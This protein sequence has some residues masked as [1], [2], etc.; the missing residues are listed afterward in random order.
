MKNNNWKTN[1]IGKR[2]TVCSVLKC[3]SVWCAC[4]CVYVGFDHVCVLRYIFRPPCWR[5]RR[6]SAASRSLISRRRFW[7]FQ[8]LNRDRDRD[9]CR[10]RDPRS[11]SR[12]SNCSSNNNSSS[13]W[14]RMGRRRLRWLYLPALAAPRAWQRACDIGSPVS[15]HKTR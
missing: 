2:R 10:Y 11:P 12:S 6:V 8:W 5:K 13:S 7:V 4:A 3:F 14:P 15:I 1:E 9:P